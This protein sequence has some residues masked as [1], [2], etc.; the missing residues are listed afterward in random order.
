LEKNKMKSF[1]DYLKEAKGLKGDQQKLDVAPPFGKIDEKDFEKLRKNKKNIKKEY[2]DDQGKLIEKPE[3]KAVA[4]YTGPDSKAPPGK[5]SAPYKAANDKTKSPTFDVE[6]NGLGELG[7]NE[8]KYE[9]KTDYSQTVVKSWAKTEGFI[10]KTKNM[11]LAEFT[12]YMLDE[13]GCGAVN[14]A[15]LPYVTAYTTGKFQPHPPEAI[16]YVVVLANKN[17]NILDS[18]VQEMKASGVLGKVLRSLLDHPE[19]YDELTSLF[20]DSEQGPSRCK[21]FAKS[22]NSNVQ[23]FVKD[24]DSVYESVSSPVGFEVEEDDEEMDMDDEDMGDE[25]MGDE[26]MMDDEEM[27][28]EDMMDDEEMEDEDEFSDKDMEDYEDMSGDE[29]EHMHMDGEEEHMHGDDIGQ[30][31]DPS[32]PPRRMKKKFAH[33]HLRDAMKGMGLS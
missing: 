27:G 8:L 18:M 26:E 11:S 2:I 5:N 14:D 32:N 21:L 29:E 20:G 9:P 31:L 22:M 28:D 24:H 16:K 33:D 1:Q 13:C 23:N 7:N 12:K 10:N 17:N 6:K 25:E 4:D 30:E 19:S 15:D 3:A